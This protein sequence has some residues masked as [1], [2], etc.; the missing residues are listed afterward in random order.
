MSAFAQPIGSA[1]GL[2]S[3]C[4]SLKSEVVNELGEVGIFVR[5]IKPT[6]KS[7]GAVVLNEED[8]ELP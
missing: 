5:T 2:F 7:G 4:F 1:S 3:A 6:T 8:R